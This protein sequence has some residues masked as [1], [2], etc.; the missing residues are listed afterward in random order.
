VGNERNDAVAPS[1]NGVGSEV[2]GGHCI[3]L[4]PEVSSPGK[5]PDRDAG[6]DLLPSDCALRS[7]PRSRPTQRRVDCGRH[8][9]RQIGRRARQL[10]LSPRHDFLR[11]FFRINGD[12]CT[13]RPYYESP[14][15][16][17][18]VRFGWGDDLGKHAPARHGSPLPFGRT[19]S[20]RIVDDPAR[21]QCLGT[22]GAPQGGA[23]L[24]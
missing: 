21:N 11:V 17:V 2:D 9:G 13:G 15:E 10:G 12:T 3:V 20:K 4:R 5:R 22:P 16:N 19:R 6:D 24:R 1:G 18:C 7:M 14:G 23:L 8:H